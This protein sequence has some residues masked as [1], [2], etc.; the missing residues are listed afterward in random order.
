MNKIEFVWGSDLRTGDPT[1][2]VVRAKAFESEEILFARSPVINVSGPWLVQ[3]LFR[4]TQA[5]YAFTSDL[6]NLAVSRI[7]AS[8]E[9][10]SSVSPS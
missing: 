6:F 4:S 7:S 10:S 1:K 5:S 2:G 8:K 9:A 3:V